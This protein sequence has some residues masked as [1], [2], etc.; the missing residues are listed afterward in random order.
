MPS[1]RLNAGGE[2]NNV[3]AIS[4]PLHPAESKGRGNLGQYWVIRELVVLP[5]RKQ[6]R[7]SSR[8]GLPRSSTLCDVRAECVSLGLWEACAQPVPSC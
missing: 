1:Q 5:A 4:T 7:W 3:K 8:G 2:T 6:P